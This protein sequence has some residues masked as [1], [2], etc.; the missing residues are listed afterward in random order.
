[1]KYYAIVNG[2]NNFN[3]IVDDWSIAEPLVK[4]AKGV[5]YK[6]FS[7]FIA[8]QTFVDSNKVIKEEKSMKKDIVI[9]TEGLNE[10]QKAA[11]ETFIQFM[12][13]NEL[14]MS[15]SGYAGTGKTFTLA[16][17]STALSAARIPV[18][19]VA[20]TNKA[21]VV[22]R[23]NGIDAKTVHKFLYE[24]KLVD[25]T[26][27]RQRRDSSEFNYGVI[28]M[29]ESSMANDEILRDIERYAQ[30]AMCKV[31]YV[32]DPGQLPSVG[33]DNQRKIFKE[34]AFKAQ[35]TEV[36]RQAN[37][38]RILDLATA[39]RNNN[40]AIPA[41]TSKDVAVV[42]SEVA[43]SNYIEKLREG[44]DATF[45][46][47]KNATRV[48][49][50]LRARAALG[51]SGM[52]V[53]GEKFI[54]INNTE[55]YANGEEFTKLGDYAGEIV[56]NGVKGYVYKTPQK[57]EQIE[58]FEDS[59][60]NSYIVVLPAFLDA[61][62]GMV[63]SVSGEMSWLFNEY[64]TRNGKTY[65]TVNGEVIIATF[66]YA[67]TGHKSQGSQWDYVFIEETFGLDAVKWFYTVVARAAKG[68]VLSKN[69]KYGAL[70]WSQIEK[71]AY[72]EE[73]APAVET[74]TPTIA[75]VEET[76]QFA[77]VPK[78]WT[79]RYFDQYEMF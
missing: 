33:K 70:S 53:S 72:G 56:L 16:R 12:Q 31:L 22:M 42:K 77:S 34:F 18:Q 35:L 57:N 73:I 50:N 1:M 45:I 78:K 49:T 55:R 60:A 69:I 28:V 26:W 62:F 8:A 14:C 71:L 58:L 10:G 9:N 67:I 59:K 21:V 27:R 41:V 52:P 37:G 38:S 36:M 13:S 7:S 2:N 47:G 40:L 32:G 24:W 6:S 20:P 19:F 76:K 43:F 48:A 25:G 30:E 15:L 74:T 17:V 66:A 11:V 3:G 61:S 63:N 65:Y 29:D 23:K 46:V 4:G 51:F 68:L 79:V 54:A 39:V 64:Q 5:L 75:P 44:K